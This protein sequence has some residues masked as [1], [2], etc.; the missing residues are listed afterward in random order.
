MTLGVAFV[1]VLVLVLVLSLNEIHVDFV[2]GDCVGVGG[3]FF[4]GS[5]GCVGVGRFFFTCRWG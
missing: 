4:L 3:M 5:D 2:G 1:V